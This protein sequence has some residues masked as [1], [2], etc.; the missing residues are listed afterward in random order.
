MLVV[1]FLYEYVTFSKLYFE[2]EVSFKLEY[3][4]PVYAIKILQKSCYEYN[5]MRFQNLR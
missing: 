3:L 5:W 1:E 4:N 2:L